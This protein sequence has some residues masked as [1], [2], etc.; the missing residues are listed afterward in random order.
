MQQNDEYLNKGLSVL[1]SIQK[2]CR[3]LLDL[4]V[5][6]FSYSRIYKNNTLFYVNNNREYF[7]EKICNNSFQ[8]YHFVYENIFKGLPKFFYQSQDITDISSARRMLC[9]YGFNVGLDLYSEFDEY[10]EV[11]HFAA[12]IGSVEF[13]D[14]VIN[15]DWVF[16]RYM[17]YFREE[18]IK[19]NFLKVISPINLKQHSSWD[20]YLHDETT[21]TELQNSAKILDAKLSKF[22]QHT[23]F[24]SSVFEQSSNPLKISR[25]RLQILFLKSRGYR[26][27][28][29]ARK[30]DIS[31][32]TVESHLIWSKET[33]GLHSSEDYMNFIH[34]N[35]KGLDPLLKIVS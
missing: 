13:T 20:K 3:P 4:G 31:S 18:L 35:F 26:M 2:I 16:Q 30:L 25:R 12:P 8:G 21:V 14:I 11:F 6:F 15:H 17:L 23:Q 5:V 28:E 9:K 32:R 7:H 34:K 24:K 19:R 27:K 22:K 1:D 33:I 10:I 29:I